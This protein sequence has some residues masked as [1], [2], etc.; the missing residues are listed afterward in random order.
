[1]DLKVEIASPEKFDEQFAKLKNPIA[2]KR[3]NKA[4]KKFLA[5]ETGDIGGFLGDHQLKGSLRAYRE[6]HLDGD[7]LLV[8]KIENN[9]IIFRGFYTHKELNNLEG[10]LVLFS[11]LNITNETQN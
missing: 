5:S 8:Y 2:L 11:S 3:L 10:S 1:M 4:V 7:C 9:T 6:L